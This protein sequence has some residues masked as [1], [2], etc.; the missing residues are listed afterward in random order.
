MAELKELMPHIK[1]AA[2]T[3]ILLL[4]FYLSPSFLSF[5][6]IVV[7]LFVIV[8]DKPF[9]TFN[10]LLNTNEGDRF[11]DTLNAGYQKFVS[12]Q[13]V[14]RNFHITQRSSC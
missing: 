4:I 9:E 8:F 1:R 7:A 2:V 14:E 10:A 6:A 3:N 11:T 5:F 12:M 13:L